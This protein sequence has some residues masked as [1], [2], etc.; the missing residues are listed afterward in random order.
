MIYLAK[1]LPVAFLPVGV[2]ILLLLA[3]LLLRKRWLAVM[4][5]VVLWLSATP[6]VGDV[7]IRTAEGWQTPVP[8]ENVPVSSAIVVLTGML[9][10]TPGSREVFEWGEAVDRFDAGVALL[11]ASR[12][13]TLIFT[14]GWLPWRPDETPEGEILVAKAL[15]LGLRPEQVLSTSRT[16]NTEAEAAAVREL[17]PHTSGGASGPSIILVTSAFHMRR[18][19]LI[20]EQAGFAVVPFPVDFQTNEGPFTMLDLLPMSGGIRNTEIAIREMY[21]YWFYR[22]VG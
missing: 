2:V 19:R 20:F 12:A 8:V 22:L 4:A 10:R 6:V 3:S 17:V 1:I 14:G 18:A 9:Q 7:L 5:L 11:R 16:P 13:P 21:G 15:A